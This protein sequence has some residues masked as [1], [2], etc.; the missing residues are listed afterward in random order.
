MAIRESE[1]SVLLN[2]PNH[3]YHSDPGGFVGDAA[4]VQPLS[5]RTLIWP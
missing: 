5:Q 3:A 1:S 2:S 4:A